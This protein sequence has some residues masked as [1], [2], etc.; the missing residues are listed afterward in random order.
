MYAVSH[1][2]SGKM[3]SNI[4][5]TV[6]I[7]TLTEEEVPLKEECLICP[8]TLIWAFRDLPSSSYLDSSFVLIQLF[9]TFPGILKSMFIPVLP[10]RS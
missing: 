6:V 8:R 1:L 9:S 7:P 2:S 4:S 5:N 10:V 3:V